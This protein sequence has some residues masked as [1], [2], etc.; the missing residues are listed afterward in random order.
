MHEKVITS[1]API[2]TGIS[3]LAV[4]VLLADWEI[5][6]F[7]VWSFASQFQPFGAVELDPIVTTTVHV[8]APRVNWP[9]VEPPTVVPFEHP[10]AVNFVPVLI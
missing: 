3:R 6:T 10:D 7:A 4:V 5:F 8:F 9:A 1:V 2:E